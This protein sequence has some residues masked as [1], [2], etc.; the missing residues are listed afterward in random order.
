MYKYPEGAIEITPI[1][2][3]SVVWETGKGGTIAGGKEL[4][5]GEL[6]KQFDACKLSIGS[7]V[8]TAT[9][10]RNKVLQAL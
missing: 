9:D 2:E 4:I 7:K 1:E 10:A 5:P 8:K 6:N 3:T